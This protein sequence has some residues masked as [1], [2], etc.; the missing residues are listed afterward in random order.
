MHLSFSDD[1]ACFAATG[2]IAY[3]PMHQHRFT[4][5]ST[6]STTHNQE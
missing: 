2:V 1:N 6:D 5:P 4:T 3:A